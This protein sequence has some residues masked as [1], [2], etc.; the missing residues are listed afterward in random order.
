MSKARLGIG[1]RAAARKRPF[2]SSGERARAHVGE[3][4]LAASGGCPRTSRRPSDSH[5]FGVE[6]PPL[7]GSSQTLSLLP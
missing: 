6:R 2:G 7:S 4:Q 1:A 3:W 5:S